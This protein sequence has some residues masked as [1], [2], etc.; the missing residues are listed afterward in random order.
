MAGINVEWAI[1]NIADDPKTAKTNEAV[2]SVGNIIK[3][4]GTAMTPKPMTISL[5]ALAPSARAGSAMR[6]SRIPSRT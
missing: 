6:T 1:Y 2:T 3:V 4:D 5:G